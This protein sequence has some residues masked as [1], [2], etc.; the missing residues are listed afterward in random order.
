[1]I[2]LRGSKSIPLTFFTLCLVLAIAC[3][4][5]DSG[6][7]QVLYGTIVGNVNDASGAAVPGATVSVT[8][9]DTNVSRETIT[10]EAGVYT[11]SNVLTG[12]YSVKVSLTGFKEFTKTDVIVTVNN[13]TRVDAVLEVGNLTET[14]TVAAEATPLQTDK[15]DVHKE[16]TSKEV[17]DLPTNIYRNYQSLIDLVPGTTPSAFQNAVTDTPAR[18]L[19]TNVNGTARNSN[20]TRL[21][22]AATVLTWLPHHVVYVAPHESIQTVNVSTN[23]FDAEQGLAGGAAITVQTKSGTNQW[24]GVAFEYFMNSI[25]RAKNFF[26]PVGSGV[27]KYIQNLYGGTLGGPI[28]KDKLFF[29]TSWEGMKERQNFSNLRT[30]ATSALRAGDFTGTGTT[31]YD[32]TTGNLD[33]S[34]RTP[35]LDNKIP[36][37]RISNVAKKM[38]DLMPATNLSGF[39]NNYYASAP[40]FYDR[41][42][43]DFKVD[44]VRSPKNTIWGKYSLLNSP[45]YCSFALGKAGGPGQGTGSCGAGQGNTRVQLATLGG[46]YTLSSRFLID[47]TIGFSRYAHRTRGPDFGTN[48]GSDVLGIPGTNGSDPRQ[49][50][51]PIFTIS[52][53]ETMGNANN[54]SPID[55]HDN[56]WTGTT[57]AS[58]SRGRHDL[59]FGLD[60]SRQHMNHWQPELGG[61]SP[62]GQF[63]FTGGVTA[64]R[65]GASPNRFNA[66]GDFLLGLPQN[67]GKALQFYDPMTTREWLFGLYFRDRWQLN[68][69]LTLTL[70]LRWEYYPLMTRERNGL[71]RYDFDDGKV[72]I[73]RY[74]DLDDNVGISVSK[75]LFAPRVGFAYRLSDKGVIRGGYGITVDPYGT[76]RPLR[77]PYPVVIFSDNEGPNTFQPFGTIEKGIPPIVGPD[78]TK[79]II[80]IPGT[81]GTRTI[82]KGEF[83]RGYIQSFNLIYER[84]LPGKLVGSVGYIATRSVR[85]FATLNLN[86]APP[87]GGSSGRPLFVKFRRSATTEIH[88]PWQTALYDSMQATLDRRFSGGLFLKTSYT[89]SKAINFQDNSGEGCCTFMYPTYWSRQRAMAGYDRTHIFRL[90]WMYEL[91]FGSNK[92]WAQTGFGKALLGGWQ[93]SGIFSAYSGTPFTVGASAASLNAPGNGQ[94][95]DQVKTEIAKLG[96]IGVNNPWLDPTA[97]KAVTEARFGNVG[98]NGLRGPGYGNIDVGLLRTFKFTERLEMQFRAES[99]N[100]TNT[101]HFN[102][103]GSDVSNASTFLSITSAAD[104]ARNFRFALRLSF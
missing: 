72:Y 4:V 65:G 80:D 52:G 15:T 17:T 29:F 94:T 44:W 55:R 90:A 2:T 46:T 24:R 98:R 74:G 76:A 35:F 82:R 97:Y 6:E 26:T 61:R 91:P 71:E 101:P 3:I 77:S 31:V 33:G 36:A 83:R 92:R 28:K 102:N 45:A 16:L 88:E 69:K 11:L 30:I 54:W 58:W 42:N 85:Q 48:F 47:G 43:Y 23:N 60:I 14:V 100:F 7:A 13:V 104:D 39:V 20:N 40:Q 32:P 19:T 37:S 27:P 79:G 12:T 50:G 38:I 84:Q 18:G 21:D 81:V 70:G 93:V 73:G 10:N 8:N 34:G 66:W 99:F 57:N 67:L 64:L 63:V 87:G 68:P 1:M 25:F 62:R 5:P 51:I 86:A 75:R 41:N 103:P 53:Y 96:G 89:W 49:S 22:G 95:A 9:K 56:T 78:I 59:R